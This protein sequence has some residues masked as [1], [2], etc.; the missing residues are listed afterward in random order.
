MKKYIVFI[1]AVLLF[2]SYTLPA[3]NRT[4]KQVMELKMPK[5]AD[6]ELC[7][8]RGAGVCWNPIT[9]KYYAAFCGNMGFPMAVFTPAGKRI[10]SDS[11]TTM[12]DIRGIW[13]NASINRIMANGYNEIGWISYELNNAGIP[14][15]ISN[16]FTGMNQP[17]EQSVGSYYSLIKSVAFRDGNQVALYQTAGE[18]AEVKESVQIHWGR[19][20]SDA[21]GDDDEN[22]GENYNGNVVAT[23]IKNAEFAFLNTSSKQIELYNYKEGYLQSTL[24]LPDTAPVESTFNFAYSNGIYWLFD[25][26]NRKWIGYK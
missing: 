12:E 8:T 25:I 18:A 4:L 24:K 5:T 20:K 17:N 11:L 1:T 15:S 9:K 22:A 3:Q 26:A 2:S 14:A 10:S 16:K 19:T 21:A 23:N 7:G 6:D 13:F